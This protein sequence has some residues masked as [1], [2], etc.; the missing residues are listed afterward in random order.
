MS[1][2]TTTNPRKRRVVLVDRGEKGGVSSSSPSSSSLIFKKIAAFSKGGY[3]TKE[4][5]VYGSIGRKLL[6]VQKISP[7][8]PAKASWF[9]GDSVISDGSAYVVTPMDPTFI[10]LSVLE[11]TEGT[12]F[13]EMDQILADVGFRWTDLLRCDGIEP[14]AICDV[15]DA[16]GPDRLFYRLSEKKTHG[17]LKSKVQRLADAFGNIEKGK[18]DVISEDTGGSGAL[19]ND[20][21]VF[22]D[23]RAEISAVAAKT[24]KVDGSPSRRHVIAAIQIL[25]G[26]VSPRWIPHLKE[27][28]GVSDEKGATKK[29]AVAKSDSST[30]PS[31]KENLDRSSSKTYRSQDDMDDILSYVAGNRGN[32]SNKKS[33]LN[34]SSAK[35]RTLAQKK[36]AKTNTKGMKSMFS[37]FKKN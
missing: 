2:E 13:M 18:G 34:D 25:E 7:V 17:W 23:K 10:L 3:L 11:A 16:F 33:K 32:G 19:A 15:N 22:E 30:S 4:T 9:V 14:A 6:E 35:P 37:F 21:T 31:K 24:S 5:R 29:N 1:R 28:M 26:Y 12:I 8:E 20:F 36:L 27:F